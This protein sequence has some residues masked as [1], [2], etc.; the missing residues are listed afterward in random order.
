[1]APVKIAPRLITPLE[2][3]LTPCK[4]QLTASLHPLQHS[5]LPQYSTLECHQLREDKLTISKLY[6]WA[7]NNQSTLDQF[8]ICGNRSLKE[9]WPKKV[10]QIICNRKVPLWTVLFA[11]GQFIWMIR[12]IC[13]RKVAV[14]VCSFCNR[15]VHL[16]DLDHL[17]QKSCRSHLSFLQQAGSFR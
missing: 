4:N 13:N 12:I 10:I 17:Q 16:D 7:C 11:T 8:G 9:V 6:P 2:G 1:M 3:S 14:L 15:F 5:H